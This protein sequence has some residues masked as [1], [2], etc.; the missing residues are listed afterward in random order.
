MVARREVQ[1]VAADLTQLREALASQV[2]AQNH[3]SSGAVAAALWDVP[4][5]LFLPGLPPESAYRDEAI[6]TIRDVDGRPVSSSS[7]PSMMAIMLDQLGLIP[8][9]RVLEIGAG[10]GYNAALMRHVAGDT[11]LIVSVDIEPDAVAGARDNL[12]RA[13]YPDVT[14]VCADGAGGYPPYAPYD[15][16]IGTVG[17]SDLAPAWLEQL[18]PG[19][20]IVAPLDLRGMQYSVAFERSGDHW[21]SRSVAPCG[22][23]RMRGELAGPE[24]TFAAG[25]G[26]FIT[27][28]DGE[29]ADAAAAA[30][31]LAGPATGRAGTGVAAAPYTLFSGLSLWL[32]LRESLWCR[33]DE[34]LAE[35]AAPRLPAA[36]ARSKARQATVGIVGSE[37]VAVLCREDRAGAE[38]GRR[39]TVALAALG[40]GPSGDALATGLAAQVRAWDAAGRPG[41]RGLRVDA[42]PGVPGGDDAGPAGA[43]D[44]PGRI[45]IERPSTRF[46]VYLDT[47]RA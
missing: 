29:R 41:A 37:G 47:R 9:Q 17:I 33:L 11:S 22:F 31:A 28:P 6:V 21:T 34:E 30:G 40:Y 23:I 1:P 13:G 4:R 20:R 39:D 35:A 45:V 7:S 14:V 3:V 15:R 25:Q 27:V 44:P 18:T 16:L 2:I 19:A 8:G 12:A 43:D 10:T 32:S 36:P 5:H 26:L 38:P 46:V 42:Y 24:R